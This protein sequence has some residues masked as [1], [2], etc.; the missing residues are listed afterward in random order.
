[1]GQLGMLEVFFNF[2]RLGL[3]RW[4]L[5]VRQSFLLSLKLRDGSGQT[6]TRAGEERARLERLRDA[7]LFRLLHQRPAQLRAAFLNGDLR[8]VEVRLGGAWMSGIL[9]QERL[10]LGAGLLI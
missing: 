5:R 4:D 8:D 6:L 7:A 9:V 1:M 2:S 10:E 3:F